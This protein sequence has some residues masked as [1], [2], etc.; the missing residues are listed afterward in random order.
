MQLARGSLLAGV[1]I[2]SVAYG[3]TR[4]TTIHFFTQ[5]LGWT[6]AAWGVGHV[7]LPRRP[8]IPWSAWGLAAGVLGVGWTSVGLAWLD[9]HLYDLAPEYPLWLDGWILFGAF[10]FDLAVGAAWRTSALLGGFLVAVDLFSSRNWSRA[11]FLTLALTALGMV[12][13]F[14]L[15][16]AFGGPF[17]LPSNVNPRVTLS[18]AT[19][20]YW[21]NGASYLNLTWPLL[22]ALAAHTAFAHRARGWTVWLGG[23]LLVFAALFLNVSKAGNVLA[24]VGLVLF[25]VLLAVARWRSR[26]WRGL[27]LSPVA[28]IGGL[29]PVV[30]IAVSLA[31]AIPQ[32][33]WEYLQAR[34]IH[35]NPR[36]VAYGYFVQ[37]LPDAGWLGFGPGSF[38]L[39]YWDYVG[40]DRVMRRAAFWVAHQ[41]YLQT[42]VEW[43]YGGTVLWGLLFVVPTWALLRRST[44]RARDPSGGDDSYAFGWRE[45]VRQAWTALPDA[46][47]PMVAVGGVIAISTTALHALVDFPMQ[48]M[49]LQFYFLIWIALGW[50][51]MARRTDGEGS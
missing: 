37:M 2:A 12:V 50:S 24:V 15:Q 8:V 40:D 36:A 51:L 47:A 32:N 9:L 17:L 14:Y 49:S 30:V 44:G 11:L 4:E 42:V 21:G 1:V 45:H 41:D 3:L 46:R 48:I 28:V 18:F 26:G 6:F 25:G 38:Q 31:F 35:S 34:D 16:R 43:G 7:L 5:W 13:F 39:A 22:A 29:V 19:F 23:A 33:R 27:R 10:D 20:R